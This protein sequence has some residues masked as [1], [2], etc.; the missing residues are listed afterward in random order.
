MN[1]VAAQQ[2]VPMTIASR[3][4]HPDIKIE[5]RKETS[6]K[7]C[8]CECKV[9]QVYAG[10]VEHIIPKSAYPRLTFT[11]TNLSFSCWV[12]NNR[13]RDFLNRQNPLLN[14]YR[15]D[16]SNHIRSF[17]PFLA[18]LNGN[19]RAELTLRRL[20]LNRPDLR[21]RRKEALDSVLRLLDKYHNEQ[22]ADLKSLLHGELLDCA[23]PNNEFSSTVRQFII[24]NGILQ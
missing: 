23:S 10:D 13:K 14:P 17:G 24:D 9:T 15:D 19:T 18:H 11:W 4:N 2:P 16:P 1:Y 22:D 12:C 21:E 5:L 6:D 7:C 3:Y 20:H 8:Y